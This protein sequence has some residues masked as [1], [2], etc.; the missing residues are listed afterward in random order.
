MGAK[1]VARQQ[2]K[3]GQGLGEHQRAWP[4]PDQ[5]AT[6]FSVSVQQCVQL[7]PQGKRGGS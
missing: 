4:E 5:I 2:Q 3:S 6:F 7:S 1:V